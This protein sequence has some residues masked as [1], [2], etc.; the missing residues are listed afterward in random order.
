M[1][2]VVSVTLNCREALRRTAASVWE[3]EGVSLEYL[4]KDGGSVDGTVE[5]LKGLGGDA[6]II[7]EPDKGI[8][9][10]MNQAIQHC[11]GRYVV[12]LNAGD[13]FRVAT[14]LREVLAVVEAH[15]EPEI[16][17]SYNYNE[18]RGNVSKYPSRLG[19][20]FLY[21][22]VLNHQATYVRRDC[23]ERH[24]GF[25]TSFVDL[26][27]CE[28]LARLVLAKGCRSALCP[29]A[30][31]N[32]QDG[33]V[34]AQERHFQRRKAQMNAIRQRH[35]ARWERMVYGT[36]FALSLYPVRRRLVTR[37]PRSVVARGYFWAANLVNRA[38]GWF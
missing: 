36:M 25:D 34:S 37:H 23:F 27:D 8:Y 2:S 20:Y 33:G 1:F 24:G 9:A 17:Y 32:Y 10:A 5:V 19:R 22:R 18:A 38:L 13:S 35:F 6:R 15:G 4:V 28:L 31:V 12:F 11:R 16:V 26:A 30:T 3:Q 21:R 7:V 29:V 14:A